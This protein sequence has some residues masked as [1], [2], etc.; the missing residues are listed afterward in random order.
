MPNA[1]HDA[2]LIVGFGG[3]EKREDVLPFLENV[4]R[5]RNVPR[6]R[7]LEVAEHY[8]HFDGVSPINGQVRDLIAALRPE[9]DAHGVGLP[10]YWGNRNWDPMLADAMRAMA[11]A[12]VTRALA[13]VLAG[14]SSY[15]SC[16]QYREDV[17]RAQEAVGDGF[18]TVD[19]IRVFYNHPDFIAA[20]AD[21]VREA[22]DQ[23][24]AGLRDS[25][26]LAFTAHSIPS[27]M[28]VNCAYERQLTETC[29]LV[30]EAVGIGGDRWALT[31]QSRSGRPTDPWL[32]PDINDHLATLKD[33]GARAVVIAPVGFLSDHMEVLYDLDDEA[34][35]TCDRLG[36]AMARA[37][38]VGTHPRFVAMLRELIQ[39]RLGAAPERRAVGQFGP[40]HDACPP[41]CCLPPPRPQRPVAA[42]G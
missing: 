12:G 13:L 7:M 26:H 27:S 10:I 34:R 30:A 1:P 9:L 4:L 24:P 35:A 38:T 41:D 21:R 32:E 29:R 20:N 31:Y 6:E 17:A 2:L 22:L 3:P 37:G 16:R 36:L 15:S 19:K 18:P 42:G 39:E 5:G 28:A 40:N 33:A 23:L 11:D 8:Y 14:Y 25:A